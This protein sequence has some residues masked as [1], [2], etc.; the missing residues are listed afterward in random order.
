VVGSYN[1]LDDLINNVQ[2]LVNFVQTVQATK[3]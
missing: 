1:S 3:S 2:T